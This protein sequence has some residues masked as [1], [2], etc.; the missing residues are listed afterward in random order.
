MRHGIQPYF[1]ELSR[2]ERRVSA[3]T[4]VVAVGLAA[5]LYLTHRAAPHTL[6]AKRFGFEGPEQLVARIE[7]E[8]H[9]PVNSP[10]N[11]TIAYVIPEQRRGGARAHGSKRPD[12]EPVPAHRVRGPGEDDLDLLARARLLALNAPVVRSEDLVIERLVQPEYPEE[13]REK[14]VEGVVE[15][16]ALVDTTGDV[17][18]VQIVGGTHDASLER[19]ASTA[20]L[21]CR[22]RPYRIGDEATRVWAAFRIAFTLD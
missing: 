22:Y 18:E 4:G 1:L 7:L 21:S 13:A 19:A 3:L 15:L 11:S 5:L 17:R 14:N 10:G 6:E 8:T 9:G 12:A 2:F 20:V 16:V